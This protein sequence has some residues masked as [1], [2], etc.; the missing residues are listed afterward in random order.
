M[1]NNCKRAESSLETSVK[2]Q[3]KKKMLREPYSHQA[4]VRA[5]P[6]SEFTV[7]VLEPLSNLKES[8]SFISDQSKS[9]QQH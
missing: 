6:A 7:S 5:E 1:G 8:Q 3:N 9:L 4:L 2:R